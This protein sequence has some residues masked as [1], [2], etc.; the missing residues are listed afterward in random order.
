M[1]SWYFDGIVI[2][3][4][5][6]FSSKDKNKRLGNRKVSRLSGHNKKV[7]YVVVLVIVLVLLMPKL[8]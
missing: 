1:M 8:N 7:N 2:L 3:G 5:S 4:I 6:C